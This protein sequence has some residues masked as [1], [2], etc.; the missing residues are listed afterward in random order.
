VPGRGISRHRLPPEEE[1]YSSRASSG[2]DPIPFD[3]R[4]EEQPGKSRKP[5]DPDHGEEELGESWQEFVKSSQGNLIVERS[6]YES[7]IYE[8]GKLKS[9]Q[10][11]CKQERRE[12]KSLNL[13]LEAQLVRE[14]DYLRN[15]LKR[16]A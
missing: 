2:E 8:L 3:W 6:R 15:L 13:K 1:D 4:G 11:I 12:N 5:R 16:K 9:W 14:L 10:E 7:M